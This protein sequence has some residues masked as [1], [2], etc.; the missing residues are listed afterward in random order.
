MKTSPESRELANLL[1][2]TFGG[3]GLSNLQQ[4]ELAAQL[5]EQW[6]NERIHDYHLRERADANSYDIPHAP[7]SGP[8]P[9]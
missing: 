9:V 8:L 6:L 5:I 1:S 3:N 4:T 2:N 7:R